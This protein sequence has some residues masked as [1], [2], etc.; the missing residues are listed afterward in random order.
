MKK[1]QTLKPFID[2]DS[3]MQIQSSTASLTLSFCI[4]ASIISLEGW[5]MSV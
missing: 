2:F 5:K 4:D 3:E 1:D